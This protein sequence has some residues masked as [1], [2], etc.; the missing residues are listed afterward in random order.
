ML[1]G[2]E[3]T[4]VRGPFTVRPKPAWFVT[5]KKAHI[6]ASRLTQ[7]EANP[8]LGKLPAILFAALG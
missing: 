8:G 3:K 4:V 6:V 5:H 1:E 7:F 2:I